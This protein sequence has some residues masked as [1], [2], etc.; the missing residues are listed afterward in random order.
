MASVG[1]A[2]ASAFQAIY[3]A[4]L[5]PLYIA[6]ELV[7][8]TELEKIPVKSAAQ[9]DKIVHYASGATV[10]HAIQA[11]ESS[12]TGFQS[13]RKTTAVQRRDILN[14]AADLLLERREALVDTMIAETSAARMWADI[15]VS[16]ASS[17]IKEIASRI[18]ALSGVIPQTKLDYALC[19]RE[20]VGPCLAIPPSVPLSLLSKVFRLTQVCSDGTPH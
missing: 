6:G 2:N 18:T 9:N 19:F 12:Y 15:N 4:D 3:E 7:P 14:K 13:W 11:C 17:H 16:I 10:K 20:P 8:S 5:V 1:T